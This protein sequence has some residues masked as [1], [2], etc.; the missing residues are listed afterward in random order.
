MFV[1][2]IE[3]TPCY[4][5]CKII[6]LSSP[7]INIRRGCILIV[8]KGIDGTILKNINAEC[9]FLFGFEHDISATAG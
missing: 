2:D 5:T 1:F 9:A 7:T 6:I 8:I 3:R 4:L